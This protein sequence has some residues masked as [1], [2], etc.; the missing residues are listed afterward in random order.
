M[1]PIL[2]AYDADGNIIHYGADSDFRINQYEYGI[3]F[4]GNPLYW[5]EETDER[6]TF[7]SLANVW[8]EVSF[9]KDFTFRSA[10]QTG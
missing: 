9:L 8:G 6:E 7:R 10:I 3:T 5:F 1:P 4:F 2:N